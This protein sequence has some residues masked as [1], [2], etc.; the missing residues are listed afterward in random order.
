MHAMAVPGVIGSMGFTFPKKNSMTSLLR[1][2]AESD[3]VLVM[4]FL[5]GGNDGLN[6]V[7]PLNYLSELNSVRPHVMLEENEVLSLKQSEVALHPVLT[8]LK[9]IQLNQY[10]R[11]RFGQR[12]LQTESDRSRLP[13]KHS[14]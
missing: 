13:R 7:I 1:L 8:D 10:R 2:A 12:S 3:K 6:T 11:R 9:Q 4:I 14:R 5:E